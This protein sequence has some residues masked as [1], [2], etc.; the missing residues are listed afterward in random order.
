MTVYKRYKI[1]ACVSQSIGATRT[2]KKAGGTKVIFVL[3]NARKSFVYHVS[4]TVFL[5]VRENTDWSSERAFL[6]LYEAYMRTWTTDTQRHPYHGAN[7]TQ[8]F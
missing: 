5:G 1:H 3:A 2:L 8:K 4:I 6:D 7:T